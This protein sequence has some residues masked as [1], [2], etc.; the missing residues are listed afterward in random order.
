MLESGN[1]PMS[2][3]VITST[4]PEASRFM[5]RFRW[6]EPMSPV[7]TTSSNSSDFWLPWSC[8]AA[9]K[10]MDSANKL[11]ALAMACRAN[12]IRMW[13]P[14][15][16]DFIARLGVVRKLRTSLVSPVTDVLSEATLIFFEQPSADAYRAIP[17]QGG[18]TARP[19]AALGPQ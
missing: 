9:G 18:L 15:R 8:D 14:L 19:R 13:L 4:T 16:V 17:F 1:L 7:T 10:A 5:S 12:F 2:S 6:R 11:D 3:A